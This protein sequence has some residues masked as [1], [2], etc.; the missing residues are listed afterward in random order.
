M[1]SFATIAEYNDRRRF[2]QQRE[3]E[4]NAR[5]DRPLLCERTIQHFTDELNGQH[6]IDVPA[7]YEEVKEARFS[8]VVREAKLGATMARP[9]LR[10]HLLEAKEQHEA[11]ER[12]KGTLR[13]FRVDYQDA[14]TLPYREE[15]RHPRANFEPVCHAFNAD[16]TVLSA[17]NVKHVM[18]FTI[19]T[20]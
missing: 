11:M 14:T 19:R 13:S 10:S 6:T 18:T 5:E 20:H 12:L 3:L 17:T 8:D 16:R 2:Q 7:L 15:C 1:T 4:F 9:K